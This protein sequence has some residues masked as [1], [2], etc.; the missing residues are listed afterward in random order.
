MIIEEIAVALVVFG[1]TGTASMMVYQVAL[2][3]FAADLLPV[4][5]AARVRWWSGHRAAVLG[6]SVV[7]LVVGLLFL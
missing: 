7:L 6:I 5:S 1:A 4:A 3:S 2:K